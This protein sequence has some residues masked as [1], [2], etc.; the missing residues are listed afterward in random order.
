MIVLTHK[1]NRIVSA[2]DYT[3]NSAIKS[4]GLRLSEALFQLAELYKNRLIVW[5]HDDLKEF[6]DEE[7]FKAIFHHKRIMASFEVRAANYISNRIGYVESSPF[8]NIKREVNYPTWLMS[9]CIGGIHAEALLKFDTTSFK[10][11]SLDYTLN[12]IAKQGIVKGLFCYSSPKLL[13]KNTVQLKPE[14]VSTYTL[15][16]FI[17]QH[18]KT[19]WTFLTF[20]NSLVYE[21]KVHLLPLIASWFVKS[22][23][24]VLDFSTIKIQ[25]NKPSQLLQ[26]I[27]VII[28]T[29]GREKYLYNV[30]QD[31]ASQTLL[32]KN[33]IIVEQNPNTGSVSELDYLKTQQWPFKINH[34]FIHQTGACNARNLALQKVSSNWVFFADDDI[35]FDKNVLENAIS[36]M[37]YFGLKA[38]TL[39]CLRK[40]EKETIN[41]IMQWHTFGSGCSIVYSNV[42]KNIAFDTAY[43]HGF[44]EDGDFGMQI[45]NLGEDIAYLPKCKLLHLK[46]PIGGFRTKV[47]QSW[48][49]EKIQ[50]KPSPTIMLFYLKYQSKF[51]RNGYKTI[52]FYKY[53][54][55][56]TNK[57]IVA[58]FYQMKKRWNSSISWA[59]KLKEQ[60][61]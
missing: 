43:E 49:K 16:K 8:I 37:S 4:T 33:V 22:K 56:Q 30:L 1:Q 15:F 39:S 19:Q 59:N 52:L 57:N 27:D 46:A 53:F 10:N 36:Y 14:K 61:N 40:G 7:G 38:A 50:P 3:S 31:L 2:F 6:I 58:Y 12:S 11:K 32:P 45:R 9:S 42:V 41:H 24:N 21:N 13:K 5:C 48:E 28:P 25:S 17:K 55:L 26:T 60:K 44:G 18:Y 23:T 47:V 35:R 29:I 54:K 34:I 20:L 51:Q